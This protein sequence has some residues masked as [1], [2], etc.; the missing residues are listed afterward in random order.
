MH[1][2]CVAG[3]KIARRGLNW[4]QS[5]CLSNSRSGWRVPSS[6]EQHVHDDAQT[7]RLPPARLPGML[8]SIGPGIVIAGSV[9]G[10]GE[11]INTPIQAARFGF[12]LL[13]AV[14][15]ACVIKYFLQVEFGRH[16]LAHNRTPFEAFNSLPGPNW[17]GVSWIGPA[18]MAGCL[19]TGLSLAGMLRATAGLFHNLLPISASPVTSTNVWSI[20]VAIVL[21]LMLWR[22]AYSDLEKLIAILVGVL[23][24]SILVGA[25]LIQGTEFRITGKQVLSGLT[26]SFGDADRAAAAAAVVSLL[27]A[28]GAT[29]NELFMYPYF[30][31]EKGYGAFAG[32]SE[33]PGWVDRA[34][35]WIRVMQVDVAVCTLLATVTTLGYFLVGAAVFHS[36]GKV[37]GGD[38]VID[39]LSE[40]LTR[41]WG[42][43]TKGIFLCGAAATI[44]STLIVATAG[45]SRMWTDMFA[46]FRWVNRH[47]PGSVLRSQ[48][49]MQ[50]VYL[51][52]CLAVSVFGAQSPEKL[53]IFA[54]YVAGLFCTPVLMIAITMLAFRTDR[55]IRMSRL[56]GVLLVISVVMIA[57]CIVVDLGHRSG[58]LGDE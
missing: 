22:G 48:R 14:I 6:A 55:R 39:Q 2:V 43:W 23:S 9:I 38:Q 12:V 29:A 40:L 53:I 20:I 3:C 57:A 50:S 10:S 44:M 25:V 45:Y 46:S 15:L 56:T 37:P 31:L 1:A 47:D 52:A 32:S 17:G 30:V 19:L 4:S 51:L 18:Y 54:Q 41:S 13:W 24:F 28:L 49:L 58:L 27:G 34:R 35:G 16:T 36:Q 26:F 33:A 5:V 21:M 8:V 11:L 42:R 7:G